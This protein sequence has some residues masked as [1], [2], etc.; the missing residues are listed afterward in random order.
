MT[1][2]V[3]AYDLNKESVRPNITAE[4]KKR[5]WAKLSESSYAIDTNETAGQ[6]Y[7]SLRPMLDGNDNLYVIPLRRPYR[8]WGP[9]DVID[10]L[11]SRLP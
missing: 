1:V 6:V 10:W 2:Y 9:Q 4:I 3:V 11:D 8:G 5:A 7:D